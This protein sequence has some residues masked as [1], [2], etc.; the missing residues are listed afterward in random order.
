MNLI[1]LEVTCSSVLVSVG[2]MGGI[3][4]QPAAPTSKD[5]L[6]GECRVTLLVQLT[7]GLL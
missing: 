1:I 3:A 7:T 6:L 5:W 4:G 2:R